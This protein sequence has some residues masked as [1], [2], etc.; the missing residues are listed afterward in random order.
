MRGREEGRG[1]RRIEQLK[2]NKAE[3]AKEMSNA[4]PST[5]SRTHAHTHTC[6]E[7]E[8]ESG[9]AG[10]ELKPQAKKNL[11]ARNAEWADGRTDALLLLSRLL[12]R[13]GLGN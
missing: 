8:K 3:R 9:R 6:R 7:R 4:H 10:D 1:K 12:P 11:A 13:A 5:H 2:T